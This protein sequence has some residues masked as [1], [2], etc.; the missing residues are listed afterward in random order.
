MTKIDLENT[1]QF[2][3]DWEAY[4]KYIKLPENNKQSL[5]NP[6]AIEAIENNLK[7][8]MKSMERVKFMSV[9]FY[10]NPLK[11]YMYLD[12]QAI[13]QSQQLRRETETMG[14][15]AELSYWRRLLA[16]FSSII[17][18]IKSP[19]T[20]KYIDFLKKIRSKHIKVCLITRYPFL[21]KA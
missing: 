14:P 5:T 21:F 10:F 12:I 19:F 4:H 3:T 15:N 8:W 17:E 13:V 11:N 6:E 16:R 9:A 20:Q 1:I 7:L 2:Y 18:H